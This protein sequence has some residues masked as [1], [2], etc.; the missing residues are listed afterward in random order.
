[1][2]PLHKIVKEVPLQLVPEALVCSQYLKPR[3]NYLTHLFLKQH[4]NPLLQ[5]FQAGKVQSKR[6]L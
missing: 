5:L 2:L 6:M 1:M 4:S 3:T